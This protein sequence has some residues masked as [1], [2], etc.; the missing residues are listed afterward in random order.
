MAVLDSHFHFLFDMNYHIL[1]SQ[2]HQN[3]LVKWKR[4]FLKSICAIWST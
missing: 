4:M 2:K 1:N 3:S